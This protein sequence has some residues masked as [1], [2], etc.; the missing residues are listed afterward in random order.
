V[1]IEYF[2]TSKFGNG[3]MVAEEFKKQMVIKEVTVNV[4]YI[5]DVRPKRHL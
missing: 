5:R 1:E 4:H 2:Y 3:A